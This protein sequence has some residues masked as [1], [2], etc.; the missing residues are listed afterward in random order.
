M[1]AQAG[2]ATQSVE[3]PVEVNILHQGIVLANA[4]GP[5]AA[6]TF[7]SLNRISYGG[8]S[9][10]DVGCQGDHIHGVIFI[11]GLGP[12]GDP[13]PPGCGHGAVSFQVP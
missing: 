13:D 10:P 6:G 5:F 7:I 12:Y 4:T 8:L 2:E 9:G 1:E 11:D 3:V